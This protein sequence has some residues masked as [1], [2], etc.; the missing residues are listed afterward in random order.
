VSNSTNTNTNT[1]AGA[2]QAADSTAGAVADKDQGGILVFVLVAISICSLIAIPMLTYTSAVLRTGQIQS[3][4]AQA[5]ELANGGA[6]VALSNERQLYDLCAAGGVTLPSSL[7]GVVTTCDVLDT[8]TLRPANEMPFHVAT[9]QADSPIPSALVTAET[10]TNPN[11]AADPAAW[12]T[13]AAWTPEPTENKVWVPQLP[14]QATSAGGNRQTTML[15]G[16]MT[17]PYTTCDVFFPGTF[18]SPI[19]I[20]GPTYFTSGVY[21]FTEPIVLADGADVVVGNGSEFGCTTDFEAI[22]FASS[23]PDPLNMSGL[24]GTFVFGANARISVEDSGTDDIRFAINQRYVSTDETSVAASSD[25]AIISVN[26]QHEPFLPGEAYG[27]DFFVAGA[28]AVPASTVGTDGDPPATD[29]DYLP[30]VLTVKPTEPDAPT[31]L[32]VAV[33]QENKLSSTTDG[34]AVVTWSTPNENGALITDYLVTDATTGKTCS[35][36]TPTLPDTTA[37]TSCTIVGLP[38]QNYDSPI[39][40][41]ISVT[42]TNMY[43]TSPSSDVFVADRVDLVDPSQVDEVVKLREP[44]AAAIG[45]SYSDGLEVTWSEPDQTGRPPIT[46]YRV[47]AT[48]GSGATFTCEARWDDPA[49]VLPSLPSSLPV[50]PPTDPPTV[51]PSYN[52]VVVAFN[53]EGLPASLA[54]SETV[55]VASGHGYVPGVDPAPAQVAA[56][57]APRVPAPIVDFR[58]STAFRLDVVIDG[59]VSVP[60]GRIAIGAANP[61][62]VDISM[63]GGVLA[64]SLWLD[65][66]NPPAQLE[67]TFDN[68][69]AQKRV[70]VRSTSSSSGMEA[71]SDAIIQVNR[72]GSIAINSWVVQ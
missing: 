39:R 7:D 38:H 21:Y 16:T 22:S 44:T 32:D 40:P 41:Q 37:Q 47:T 54:E 65:P 43:G 20:D 58:T 35:P 4:R 52:I 60:Q 13:S 18:T 19:S 69:V 42:A 29:S 49:C 36:E 2:S 45:T 23:V 3:N 14:V 33:Y 68:P 28:A 5:V 24:G 61:S 34:M 25:V 57:A 67:V 51:P 71:T 48:D 10:Y 26:G 64:G 59:Y 11:T 15:P 70:R 72:S 50:D 63:T 46:G 9:V 12:L 55:S 31:V 62:T 66:T 17:P 8:A 53:G 1:G 56:A 27:Q 30:S 6:W